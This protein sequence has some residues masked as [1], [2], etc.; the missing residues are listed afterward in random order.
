MVLA[1]FKRTCRVFEYKI[2]YR[3]ARISRGVYLD[4]DTTLGK[5]VEILGHSSIFGSA[6]GNEITIHR[7]CS[8]FDSKFDGNTVIYSNCFLSKVHL[9]RFSYV[10]QNSHLHFITLGSFS[11]IGP[12]SMGG[13][14]EHPTNFLSTSPTFF[15]NLKQCGTSFSETNYFKESKEI[16]IGHDVWIGARVY[17]KDGVKIGNGAVIGAGAVVVKDVPDYAVVGGVPAKIIRFRF[18]KEIVQELLNIQWWEWSER[19][20]QEAQPYFVKEDITAFI[21]WARIT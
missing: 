18:P 4:K 14:G 17:I 5:N 2:R 15:S 13:Y 8:I 19:R 7:D 20:L 6:L 3:T 21:Q 1:S 9:G 12:C 16:I 10:A 11:S